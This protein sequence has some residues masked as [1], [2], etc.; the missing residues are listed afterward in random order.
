MK[1]RSTSLSDGGPASVRWHAESQEIPGRPETRTPTFCS[2]PY[3]YYLNCKLSTMEAK[4]A[5]KLA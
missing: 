1:F 3:L 2:R 5:L 4:E